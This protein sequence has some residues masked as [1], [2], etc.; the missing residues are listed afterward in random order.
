MVTRSSRPG[1]SPD[2]G[3]VRGVIPGGRDNSRSPCFSPGDGDSVHLKT[4]VF[5]WFSADHSRKQNP[6]NPRISR[7]SFPMEMPEFPQLGTLAS[8]PTPRFTTPGLHVS[9]SEEKHYPVV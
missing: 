4:P 9:I 6:A 5:S 8:Q 2:Y 1:E 3:F 7:V